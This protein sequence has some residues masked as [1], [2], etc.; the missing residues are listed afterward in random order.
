MVHRNFLLWP[1]ILLAVTL[2]VVVGQSGSNGTDIVQ[3]VDEN[4]SETGEESPGTCEQYVAM[5]DKAAGLFERTLTREEYYAR[6]FMWI[7]CRSKQSK[8][9]DV[10]GSWPGQ[11]GLD[12]KAF[13]NKMTIIN[14]SH[15]YLNGKWGDAVIFFNMFDEIS[16]ENMMVEILSFARAASDRSGRNLYLIDC[17]LPDYP[18]WATERDGS[19]FFNHKLVPPKKQHMARY[20]MNTPGL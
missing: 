20:R 9:F 19:I 18:Y 5:R 3:S 16:L 6:D 12:F 8:F 10:G 7:R 4:A 1:Y 11:D 14:W 13:L 2:Q 17:P 15:R